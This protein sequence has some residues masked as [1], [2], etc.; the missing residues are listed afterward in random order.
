[1]K[2]VRRYLLTAAG[3]FLLA[4]L[5]VPLLADELAGFYYRPRVVALTHTI[6]LGWIT[7]TIMGASFQLLPIVMERKIRSEGLVIV[8]FWLM[9]LGTVG[10]VAHFAIGRWNGL[11]WAAGLVAIGALCHLV[12][13]GLSLRPLPR[14]TATAQLFVLALAG[15]AATLVFGFLLALDRNRPF[16]PE[17]FLGTLGAHFHLAFLGW[18]AAM[19]LGMAARTLPMFLLVEDPKGWGVTVQV[20][21]MALGVPGVTVALLT[22]SRALPL[23]ALVVASAGGAFLLQTLQMVWRRRR[24]QL[25]WGLRFILTGTAFLVPTMALGLGLAFTW[26]QSPTLVMAY[27]V[28]ALGGWTSLTIVGMLLKIVPFLVWYRVY[29][30]RAG[31]EPV[32]TLAQLSWP[33]AERLSY[34]LLTGGILALAL[35]VAGASPRGIR[36]AGI[37][38]AAGALAFAA[39][40]I[41]VVGHVAASPPI[42]PIA[43]VTPNR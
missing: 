38:L 1:M 7:L 22:E 9:V 27:A 36:A 37:A 41:R 43:W 11:A 21:G 26:L 25:D 5:A 17:P 2:G 30:G 15:L 10:M 8:Q 18:I 39:T 24:P 31:P 28:M 33:A 35:A 19:I 4:A 40:L 42:C 23:A 34:W 6:T 3:A 32:P 13:V 29:G 12:N 14:W 16:L 20:W